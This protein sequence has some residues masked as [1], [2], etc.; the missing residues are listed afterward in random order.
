[1]EAQHYD[2]QRLSDLK[3]SF[4][5]M[6]FFAFP[7][8]DIA[9]PT[10]TRR[11]IC[12][13]P[14]PLDSYYQ[15]VP[16]IDFFRRRYV[17]FSTFTPDFGVGGFHK[18]LYD[19][20]VYNHHHV[21]P[22]LRFSTA[23]A[24]PSLSKPA[25]ESHECFIDESALRSSCKASQSHALSGIKTSVLVPILTEVVHDGVPESFR[26]PNQMSSAWSSPSD[27]LSNQL[28]TLLYGD[29]PQSDVSSGNIAVFSL[30]PR[31]NLG[32]PLLSFSSGMTTAC[33][34]VEFGVESVGESH[35]LGDCDGY[36][37]GDLTTKDGTSTIMAMHMDLDEDSTHFQLDGRCSL[38]AVP[39]VDDLQWSIPVDQRACNTASSTT[40]IMITHEGV[41]VFSVPIEDHPSISHIE[42]HVG[43]QRVKGLRHPLFC[44]Q[45]FTMPERSSMTKSLSM[46]DT[47]KLVYSIG[48]PSE[49]VIPIKFDEGLM[50]YLIGGNGSFDAQPGKRV[51]QIFLC[52]ETSKGSPVHQEL[53]R[54]CSNNEQRASLNAQYD[55]KIGLYKEYSMATVPNMF[56]MSKEE[57]WQDI[58]LRL[59]HATAH[60]V[61]SWQLMREPDITSGKLCPHNYNFAR[62]CSCGTANNPT[63]MQPARINYTVGT[64]FGQVLQVDTK[65]FLRKVDANKC[66][67]NQ[68]Q[69]TVVAVDDW[70]SYA[71]CYHLKDRLD[72][73]KPDG[74]IS[75]IYHRVKALGGTIEVIRLDFAPEQFSQTEWSQLIQDFKKECAEHGIALEAGEKSNHNRCAKAEQCIGSALSRTRSMLTHAQIPANLS[76][77][78]HAFAEAIR[79]MNETPSRGIL[80]GDGK[81][82]SP[83]VKV[84]NKV[85]KP[86]SHKQ[87]YFGDRCSIYFGE[88]LLK[89]LGTAYANA[90]PRSFDNCYCIGQSGDTAFNAPGSFKFFVCDVQDSGKVNFFTLPAESRFIVKEH[91]VKPRES[92]PGDLHIVAQQT[93]ALYGAVYNKAIRKGVS[94]YHSNDDDIPGPT[95]SSF[96]NNTGPTTAPMPVSVPMSI[97]NSPPP[98]TSTTASDDTQVSSQGV[99]VGNGN[100]D[101]TSTNTNTSSTSTS[102]PDNSP[103]TSS[104]V[105]SSAPTPTPTPAPAT[106]R[107]TRSTRGMAAPRLI[108][109][110]LVQECTFDLMGLKHLEYGQVSDLGDFEF[111]QSSSTMEQAETPLRDLES[112]PYRSVCLSNDSD[113]SL[114]FDNP[115]DMDYCRGINDTATGAYIEAL[116]VVDEDQPTVDQWW[117]G[118]MHYEWCLSWLAEFTQFFDYSSV[119]VVPRTSG[120]RVMKSTTRYVVKRNPDG[121]IAKL[122]SRI[123]ACGYSQVDG[124][125]F[126]SDSIFSPVASA[127]SF[128]IL[129]AIAAA[130]RLP[131]Y[132]AD[133]KG[134]FHQSEGFDDTLKEPVYMEFPDLLSVKNE[135]T[136]QDY[137]LQLKSAVYGMKQASAAFYATHDNFLQEIGFKPTDVDQCLYLFENEKGDYIYILSFVD[138]CPFICS[139]D[140]I[141]DWFVEIYTD[142]FDAVYE[143]QITKFLGLEVVADPIKNIYKISC[144]R[145][146]EKI[147]ERAGRL[148]KPPKYLPAR[149]GLVLGTTE[150]PMTSSE[151][152]TV[153]NYN[154]HSQVGSVNYAITMVRPDCD[155]V[156]MQIAKRVLTPDM[157][158]IRAM[159]HLMDYLY[160]TKS[161]GLTYGSDDLDPV[162]IADAAGGLIQYGGGTPFASFVTMSG[163]AIWWKVGISTYTCGIPEGEAMATFEAVDP[164][165][166]SWREDPVNIQDYSHLDSKTRT[167]SNVYAFKRTVEGGQEVRNTLAGLGIILRDPTPV[168]TDCEPW[169]KI[170]TN[171]KS[172]SSGRKHF[173]LAFLGLKQ[174]FI[175][176]WDFVLGHV[177]GGGDPFNPADI[178]TKCGSNLDKFKFL[179]D[180]YLGGRQLR[181]LNPT[182]KSGTSER[183]VARLSA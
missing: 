138:D 182:F 41:F 86:H 100:V 46:R 176:N 32:A 48:K 122:K 59:G 29:G 61:R 60:A 125:N 142:R 17:Y 26:S 76:I 33:S 50:P 47:S 25:H 181:E 120:M 158:V 115:N 159:D 27:W 166:K 172:T 163:A 43:A 149:S 97:S 160:T 132:M 56:V 123:C 174:K 65:H 101:A 42:F 75:N 114:C 72:I 12:G 57:V 63:R 3:T 127:T 87:V 96:A 45:L 106:R 15:H 119:E 105:P 161:L 94:V 141:R 31:S 55:L 112:T 39:N 7:I 9:I 144:E 89:K 153:S 36:Y 116:G 49:I 23:M 148:G 91:L 152:V 21:H 139:S 22:S 34:N 167:A 18:R 150:R 13:I 128:R 173:R 19:K 88:A 170:I 143:G 73:H 40:S 8:F 85:P 107:S 110:S 164:N 129:M 11:W 78:F 183:V 178:N 66:K 67:S 156:R 93:E 37:S 111:V 131:V 30:Q 53:L 136:G 82:I 137:V 84:L 74:F 80:N 177:R 168:F 51:K 130:R 104:G 165:A 171:V 5:S 113:A 24:I 83:Y 169:F 124:L 145:Y 79:I 117:G 68:Y 126:N 77:V 10:W 54:S 20:F 155:F 121:S 81:E 151:R 118:A 108:A 154:I 69:H 28:C 16:G 35:K 71:F 14:S 1:M 99:Y 147:V 58:H 95:S 134:A 62:N 92:V 38:F 133:V 98:T 157:L 44:D 179:R 90:T 2:W 109:N 103:T 4:G 6:F 102:A 70:S 180:F 162:C 175:K 135:S 64:Y 146:I 52:G 140:K